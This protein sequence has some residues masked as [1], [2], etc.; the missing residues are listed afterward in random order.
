VLY[1]FDTNNIL[2]E[3]MKSR[4]DAEAIRAY[5]VLY[6]KLTEEGLK[7]LFQTM[8]NE[9]SSALKMFLTS[10]EM[11]FQLLPPHIH[12]QNAT[13]RAIQMFKNHFISGICST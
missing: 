10:R 7:T 12:R 4:S 8:D 2:A 5:T 6:N 1:D 13:E 9:A 3:P 11:T